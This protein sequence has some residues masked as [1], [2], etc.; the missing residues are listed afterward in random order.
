M[1][2]GKIALQTL[3]KQ[4]KGAIDNL[5]K[6]TESILDKVKKFTKP[7]FKGEDGPATLA[8]SLRELAQIA[9]STHLALESHDKLVDMIIGDLIGVVEQ[10]QSLTTGLLQTSVMTEVMMRTCIDKELFTR[11]ELNES[12]KKVAAQT[13][14]QMKDMKGN[15][16]PVEDVLKT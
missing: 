11:E 15:T 9:N 14:E 16:K 13:Q 1:E 2:Q 4:R 10:T 5:E 8:N 7:H 12:H 3:N 6:K